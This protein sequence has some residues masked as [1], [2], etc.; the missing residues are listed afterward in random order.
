MY[1]MY[2]MQITLTLH[3][4]QQLAAIAAVI[5]GSQ[6]AGALA[7]DGAKAAVETKPEKKQKSPAVTAESTPAS[8]TPV[9]A[10]TQET[11]AT[12]EAG[13]AAPAVDY[14]AVSKA[15]TDSVKT[16][17]RD[18]VVSTL[19]SFGAAKGTDLKAEQY[20]EFVETLAALPNVGA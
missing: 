10:T 7:D 20:A 11:V 4:A 12:P 15:I 3:N 5:N 14:P 2:P 6:V 19:N 8:T 18:A 1:P 9:T 16:K 17:G 13:T